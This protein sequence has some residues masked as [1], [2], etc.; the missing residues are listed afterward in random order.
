MGFSLNKKNRSSYR[1]QKPSWSIGNTMRGIDSFG[2]EVP[3]F[4][5]R[6]ENRINTVCGGVFTAVILTLALIYA[7]LKAIDLAE[8]KNPTISEG[9]VAEGITKMSFDKMGFRFA[10]TIEDSFSHDNKFDT[11]YNK[12]IA[13]VIGNKGGVKFEKILPYH[14]CTEEDFAQF[15]PVT[16]EYARDVENMNNDPKRGLF[17]IDVPQ[18]FEL[19][20]GYG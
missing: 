9:T 7:S 11:R 2:Q 15:Y 14:R 17:C 16:A 1:R 5:L 6:G 19:F 8:R 20:G 10:F 3:S 4:N 13:R 12:V 18:D